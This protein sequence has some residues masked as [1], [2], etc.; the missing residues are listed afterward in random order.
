VS[1]TYNLGPDGEFLVREAAN[2]GGLLPRGNQRYADTMASLLILGLFVLDGG[3]RRCR[4]T[5]EGERY[6][7]ERGWVVDR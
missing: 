4:L 6:A 2:A 5:T 7:A 3:V 1:T